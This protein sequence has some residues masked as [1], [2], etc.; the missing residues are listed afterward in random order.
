M[1]W[2][3]SVDIEFKG[4]CTELV[5]SYI[6]QIRAKIKWSIDKQNKQKNMYEGSIRVPFIITG[7]GIRKSIVDTDHFVSLLDV[8]PTLCDLA[9]VEQQLFL[10][11]KITFSFCFIRHSG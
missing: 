4:R 8:Y 3:D 10:A 5:L 11:W 2:T 1:N 7:L 9:N 6:S